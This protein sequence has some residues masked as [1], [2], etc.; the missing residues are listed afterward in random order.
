V[1]GYFLSLYPV[2]HF[3]FN[4]V[5]FLMILP[6]TQVIVVFFTAAAFA[7]ASCLAFSS[8]AAFASASCL[9]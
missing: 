2:G 4:A 5:T 1:Q 8:A 3:G 6:L 9:A 7:S